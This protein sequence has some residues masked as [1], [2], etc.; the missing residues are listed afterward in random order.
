[1]DALSVYLPQVS[2][3]TH[4]LVDEGRSMQGGRTRMLWSL[5]GTSAC[6][7]SNVALR[8]SDHVRHSVWG[9]SS[10]RSISL[11]DSFESLSQIPDIHIQADTMYCRASSSTMLEYYTEGFTQH[12]TFKPCVYHFSWAGRTIASE[13]L[14]DN[15]YMRRREE[16][17]HDRAPTSML[18]YPDS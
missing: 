6:D 15:F 18:T 7:W 10:Q 12:P 17:T 3:T 5:T 4:G 16:Y 8:N 11:Q 1:M 2:A 14:S 9:P 13:K